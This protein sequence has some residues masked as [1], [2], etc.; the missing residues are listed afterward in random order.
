MTP[1]R[2]DEIQRI[3]QPVRRGTW[4][5]QQTFDRITELQRALGD[6]LGEVFLQGL[7]KPEAG[8]LAGQAAAKPAEQPDLFAIEIEPSEM[9][10]LESAEAMSDERL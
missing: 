4:T 5:V 2:F 1:A 8:R 10:W 3:A 7:D 6:L 9:E